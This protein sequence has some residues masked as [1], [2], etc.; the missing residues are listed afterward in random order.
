MSI[1]EIPYFCRMKKIG[2]YF[3]LLAILSFVAYWVVFRK[4]GGLFEKDEANFT[5]KN[6]SKIQTIFLSNLKNEHVKL[7]RTQEGWIMNDSLAVR[8]DAVA[9]LLEA[10]ENQR[11][12]QPVSLGYHDAAIRELSGNSTKVEVYCGDEKTHTFYVARNPGPENVTYMLSEGAKRPYIVGFPI[13]TNYVGSRYYTDVEIWRDRK[14]MYAEAPIERVD[15]NYHDS[16]QYSFS[17][18]TKGDSVTVTGNRVIAAPLNV[19]RVQSYLK[20]IEKITCYGFENS[21][22]LKDSIV[23][24]GRQLATV[25]IQRKGKKAEQLT[26]YFRPADKGTK[27]FIELDGISYDFDTFFGWLNEKDFILLSRVT[28]EKMLRT[29]PEFYQADK[30]TP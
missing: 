11:A 6:V 4:E 25:H 5:V 21:N 10:L 2:L 27:G 8:P 22:R 18:I 3:I 19:K 14:I 24:H 13:S 29:F 20:L 9:L 16:T 17:L 23:H 15:V 1:V 26:L 28:S 7:S 30:Q 12:E